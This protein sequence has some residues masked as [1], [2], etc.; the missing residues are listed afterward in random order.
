[1]L[2]VLLGEAKH[3][4]PC[5]ARLLAALGMTIFNSPAL[6]RFGMN[7]N[8]RTRRHFGT[9]GAGSWTCRASSSV[10]PSASAARVQPSSVLKE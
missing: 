7:G 8:S 2:N 5:R 9:A 4:T 10:R 1:M 6:S 3:P